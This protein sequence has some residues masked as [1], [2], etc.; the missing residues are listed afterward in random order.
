[1]SARNGPTRAPPPGQPVLLYLR[2]VP[3]WVFVD[4]VRQFVES[5]C[6][7]AGIGAEREGQLALATHELMQNGI[8][9]G[10]CED[11]ELRLSIDA[12]ADQVE[13]SLTNTC[14]PGQPAQLRA[15]LAT[16]REQEPLESYVRAMG[17]DPK[18]PGGLG[19]ARIRYEAQLELEV[20]ESGDRLTVSARGK[21]KP[22]Q[23]SAATG[24][25]HG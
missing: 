25:G 13:V 7:C 2:M 5:F 21:L 19:L 8:T 24:V 20:V 16:L 9:Y 1:M 12:A 23:L 14:A 6:A 11:I 3:V 15:R 18:A 10:T 4:E 17:A 22:A